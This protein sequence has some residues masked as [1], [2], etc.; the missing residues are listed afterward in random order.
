MATFKYSARKGLEKITYGVIEAQSEKEAV[1]KLS[2]QGF[3]PLRVELENKPKQSAQMPSTAASGLRPASCG[4][5]RVK[6]KEVTIFSRELSSLL[7]SGVPILRALA[8]ISEQSE[9]PRLRFILND[10]HSAIKAG[11]SFCDAFIRYPEIFSTV[12]LAIIH[13]G[14]NSGNLAQALSKIADY[15][16]K[17]EEMFSHFRMALAYPIL[18][19][20]VGMATIVFMFVFVMP[21]L[22]GIYANLGQNL[23]LPTRILISLSNGLKQNGL[24]VIFIL[25]I[26]FILR[27]RQSKTE[28]ARL[29]RSIFQLRLPLLGKFILKLELAR[30]SRTL[31]VLIKNGIAILKAIEL[32]TAVV[33]NE[34]LKAQLRKGCQELKEGQSFG[35]SLKNSKLFPAF[36]TN[37]IAVGEES[38][39][40][41][42]ALAEVAG[43]YE[44]DTDEALKVLN[45]LLEPLLILTMGLIVGFIVIAMLL[46]IFELNMM[47][48]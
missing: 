26:A 15:R 33:E 29:S 18:M 30:F 48:G 2:Q 11:A 32:S 9:N 1:E 12:H 40:L 5:G 20:A 37:L 42:E 39:R 27:G 8:L 16:M 41:D 13:S 21:R 34:L 17:Q 36:M 7:K 31:E 10:V 28:R 23:P 38:G 47:G 35:A 6:L 19:A 14:E 25:A 4:L 45:S 44:R 24:W 43:F 3:L 46:P 22:A